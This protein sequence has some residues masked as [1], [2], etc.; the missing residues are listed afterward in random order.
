MQSPVHAAN[1]DY[2]VVRLARRLGKAANT[3]RSSSVNK[4]ITGAAL[5]LLAATVAVRVTTAGRELIVAYH[6]GTGDALDAFLIAFVV[7][8]F[9]IN[10]LIGAFTSA[11]LPTFVDV[12]EKEGSE[13]AYRLA[14]NALMAVTVLVLAIILILWVAGPFLLR[15]LASGFSSEKLALA[16]QL[17][18]LLLPLIFFHGAAKFWGTLLQAGE[19]FALAALTPASAPI[20]TIVLLLALGWWG[21]IH[22]LAFGLIVGY[23]CEA[24]ILAY[25]AARRGIPVRPGWHGLDKPTRI[26]FQQYAPLVLGGLMAG[27]TTLVDQSMA[28]MLDAGSVASLSYGQKLVALIFAFT[29][30]PI[31]IALLPFLSR[32]VASAQFGEARRSVAGW[33][34]LAVL[35]TAPLTCAIYIFSEFIVQTVF[36]RGAFTTEDTHVVAAV[37]AMYCLQIPFYLA[38]IIGARMLNALRLS[39][40][41]AIIGVLNFTSNIFFNWLFMQLIGLPGIALSTSFVYLISSVFIISCLLHYLKKPEIRYAVKEPS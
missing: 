32:Q 1:V 17:Q 27:G 10:V 29:A 23:A 12:R 39:H 3:W 30:R 20:A 19:R 40:L 11:L 15:F 7:P 9:V 4:R 25:G 21:G 6:F 37:Q 22:L 26:V 24:G 34:A 13:A 5:I 35:L 38:G 41:F 33:I 14:S 31:G 36:E 8:A 28:A 18:R 16:V 2:G